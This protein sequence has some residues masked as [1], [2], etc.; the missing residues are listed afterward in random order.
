MNVF[1]PFIHGGSVSLSS[2]LSDAVSVKILR[3]T[4][5]SQTLLLANTLSFSE[6]SST[7]A[8]VL[9]KGVNCSEYAPVLLHTIYLSSDLVSGPVIVGLGSSL[10]FEGVQLLLGNDLTGDKVVVNPIV[11]DVPC[12]EQLPDPVEKEIRNRYPACAETCAMSEKNSS[13]E[14]A[15]VDLADTFM[16]QVFEKTVVEAEDEA[17]EVR[18]EA[19]KQEEAV[20]YDEPSTENLAVET[21]NGSAENRLRKGSPVI[22]EPKDEKEF[23]SNEHSL[24]FLSGA[25]VES[26]QQ[27]EGEVMPAVEN[28]PEAAPVQNSEISAQVKDE[29]IHLLLFSPRESVQ[30][31]LGLNP[32]EIIFGHTVREPLKPLKLLKEKL[33]S[34][35]S[36]FINL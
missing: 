5:A 21:T 7:G 13:N 2:D 9:I 1:E 17:S 32:F 12:V 11:T 22:S 18:K 15:E 36:N 27:I 28:Q 16:I 35:E 3:D 29:G 31:S 30:E 10:P 14:N 20:E 33:L 6:K 23:A 8:S 26:K 4:G 19:A 24:N 34:S 25:E